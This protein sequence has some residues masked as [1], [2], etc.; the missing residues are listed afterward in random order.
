[1]ERERFKGKAVLVTG[2]AGGIG[3]A[4]ATAFAREGAAVVIADR[5]EPDLRRVTHLIRSAGGEAHHVQADLSTEEGVCRMVSR[6]LDQL[7]RIDVVF[8][9]AGV[10]TQGEIA[11]FKMEEY[12][13][14]FDTNV[15]ALFVLLREALPELRK[16]KGV[17]VATSSVAGLRGFAKGGLYSASKHAVEGIIKTAALENARYGV[18]MSTIN[19]GVVETAMF[20]EMAP[21][22]SEARRKIVGQHPLGRAAQPEDMTGAVLFLASEEGRYVTGV[23]LPVDGGFTLQ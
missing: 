3:E 8:A 15:R 4:A 9:N 19:P 1:M 12:D 18:R 21:P 7:G 17:V 14:I 2:G 11:E 23:S 5:N 6:T 10:L 22:G 20:D 13:R 16:S